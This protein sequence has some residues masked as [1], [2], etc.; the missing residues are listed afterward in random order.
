M[1]L[2]CSVVKVLRPFSTWLGSFGGSAAD[3]IRDTGEPDRGGAE[4]LPDAVVGF[5]N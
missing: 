5:V 4:R 3:G 2:F 1:R